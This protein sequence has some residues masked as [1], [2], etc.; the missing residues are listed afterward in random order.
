MLALEHAWWIL[1]LVESGHLHQM[2]SFPYDSII[3]YAT[4]VIKLGLSQ[5]FLIKTD[6]LF[7]FALAEHTLPPKNCVD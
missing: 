7:L 3:I 2:H 4:S 6:R 5:L 1:G